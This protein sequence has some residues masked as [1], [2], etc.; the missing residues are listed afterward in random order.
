MASRIGGGRDLGLAPPEAAALGRRA[1][2]R[3]GAAGG[4]DCAAR[5]GAA[6]EDGAPRAVAG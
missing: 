3:V 5:A 2:P 1:A 4:G 6:A